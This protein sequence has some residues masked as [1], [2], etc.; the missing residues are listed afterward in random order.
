MT[1]PGPGRLAEMSVSELRFPAEPVHVR[2]ARLV[3][4]AVARQSGL[5]DSDVEDI[6]LAV[7]EACSLAL[8]GCQTLRL[9]FNSE[10][11]ALWISVGTDGILDPDSDDLSPLWCCN[12]WLRNSKSPSAVCGCPGRSPE[13]DCTASVARGCI[14][15]GP[16]SAPVSGRV[17][18]ANVAFA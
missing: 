17:C 6:R 1:L 13:T 7:G 9:V 11:T 12:P 14:G 8:E 5:D 4:G 2:T 18:T 10:D 15:A 16:G 3:A